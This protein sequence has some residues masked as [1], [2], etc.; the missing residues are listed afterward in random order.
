M[1]N[2]ARWSKRAMRRALWSVFLVL[3]GCQLIVNPFD[4]ELAK[5]PPITTASVEGARTADVSSKPLRRPYQQ[6]WPTEADGRVTHAPLYYEMPA[7]YTGSEND[8]FAWGAV[9]YVHW[10]DGMGRFLLSSVLFPVHV[11]ITPPW[12]VMVSDGVAEECCP[13]MR[14]DAARGSP[15]ESPQRTDER[16]P[17]TTERPQ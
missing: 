17:S 11:I 1:T 6:A 2:A 9:D 4:D 5:A 3:P 7:V 12:Q 15:G 14:L 16:A 13:G 10:F 8:T